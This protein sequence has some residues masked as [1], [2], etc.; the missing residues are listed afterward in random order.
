[1]ASTLAYSD[2]AG[3]YLRLLSTGGLHPLLPK[4]SDVTFLGWF[5]DSSQLLAS[6]AIP[7]ARKTKSGD[8]A[9]NAGQVASSRYGLLSQL[10]S[11]A[12]DGCRIPEST[13]SEIAVVVTLRRWVVPNV[14]RQLILERC[15]PAPSKILFQT[16]SV[17]LPQLLT[18]A[19]RTELGT[20]LIIGVLTT[21]HCHN[22]LLPSLVAPSQDAEMA[23]QNTSSFPLCPDHRPGPT[24][25]SARPGPCGGQPA[26]VVPTA[27]DS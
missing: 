8:S 25:I 11:K 22:G 27:I 14:G 4:T 16:E 20:T 1:M 19:L 23:W 6:W 9:Q 10:S 17:G 18:T 13:R 21:H 3:V 2:K 7:P 5:P 26:M 15:I 12:N 24:L